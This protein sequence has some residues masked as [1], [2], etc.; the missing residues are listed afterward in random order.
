MDTRKV[1]QSAGAD[2]ARLIEYP[3]LY[4]EIFN[5]VEADR[6]QVYADLVASLDSWTAAAR[7]KL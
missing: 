5:E 6:A 7:A 4:H 3:G 1:V 2:K